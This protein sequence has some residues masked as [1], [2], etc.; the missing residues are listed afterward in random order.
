MSLDTDLNLDPDDI[1]T[2]P[3]QDPSFADVV[4]SRTSRRAV[5]GGGMAVAAGFLTTGLAE[6]AVATSAA[7]RRRPLLGFTPIPLGYADEVVVPTGYRAR[8]S[9]R[10]A[11]RSWAA[12][13]RSYPGGNTAAEQAQQVG[14]HHDGMH[15]FPRS[16]GDSTR[17]LLVVNHEYT[18]EGYLHTGTQPR[19]PKSAWTP[20]MVAKSQAAH[21]VSV[22]E[23]KQKTPG[24]W[25]V[26]RSKL[27]RRIT[28]N[29]RMSFSGP[30]AGHRLVRTRADPPGSQARWARSTTAPTG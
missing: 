27:N 14:M 3:S 10:G 25:D 17:G 8:R 23:V 24:D 28:A 15:F 12:T 2:N 22:V 13:R 18:D 21:G 16:A 30:A 1:S 20:E 11:P 7:R 6:P 29:T 5:L 26:V 19:P 9:S 4:E